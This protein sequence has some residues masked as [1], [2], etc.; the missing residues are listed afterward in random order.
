[1]GLLAVTAGV[2]A[3]SDY[4]V[5]QLTTALASARDA[6]A[7]FKLSPED[8]LQVNTVFDRLQKEFLR[9]RLDTSQ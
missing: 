5:A 2:E 6:D 3:I 1:M 8:G 7:K 4:L 9:V